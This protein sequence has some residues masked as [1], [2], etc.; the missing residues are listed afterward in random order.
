MPLA[1]AWFMLLKMQ[2][3]LIGAT[4]SILQ[5]PPSCNKFMCNCALLARAWDESVPVDYCQDMSN[6]GE[7]KLVMY[8]QMANL[9]SLILPSFEL[10]LK[11]IAQNFSKVV[12][13]IHN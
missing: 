12:F 2:K 10:S 4:N 13:I 9:V 7:Q 11:E 3:Q 1:S 5:L 6:I 8:A